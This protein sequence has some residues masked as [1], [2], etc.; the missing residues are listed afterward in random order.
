LGNATGTEGVEVA[1]GG[2][3]FEGIG[4]R[5]GVSVD[6][7]CVTV[8]ITSVGVAVGTL[9]GRL[10]ALIAKA[11]TSMDNKTCNFITL[12][13]IGVIILIQMPRRWQ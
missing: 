6:K 11:R 9:E 5:V 12:S 10:Q 7:G 13:F 2:A 3:V 4:V 8:G 1:A